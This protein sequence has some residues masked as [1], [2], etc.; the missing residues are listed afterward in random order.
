MVSVK[1]PLKHLRQIKNLIVC[2]ISRFQYIHV[3]K[4]CF[5]LVQAGSKLVKIAFIKKT[6]VK[7]VQLFTDSA[8]LFLSS[9]D[10]VKP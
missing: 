4:E 2:I 5:L 6:T 10:L 1:I 3:I 9:L 7:Q 8:C